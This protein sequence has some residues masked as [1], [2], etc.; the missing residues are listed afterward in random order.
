MSGPAVP[1]RAY[2]PQGG[3][4]FLSLSSSPL[5]SSVVRSDA[6]PCR[7]TVHKYAESVVKGCL[8]MQSCS[9]FSCGTEIESRPRPRVAPRPD[10]GTPLPFAGLQIG[11]PGPNT[12]EG[13]SRKWSGS[14]TSTGRS[15]ATWFWACG[16]FCWSLV[17]ATNI[18]RRRAL[19][20]AKCR[21]ARPCS[22]YRKLYRGNR[23]NFESRSA[24]LDATV[25]WFVN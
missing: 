15:T 23:Y 5:S 11:P 13:C 8:K 18:P 14:P 20:P 22:L 17:N 24:D 25:E 9:A 21:R 16:S 10:V 1:S 7:R 2:A 6:V 4:Q 3:R 12:A 19:G